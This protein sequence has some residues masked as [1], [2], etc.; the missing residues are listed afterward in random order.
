[1]EQMV[2]AY[3][4][5]RRGAEFA[6]EQPGRPQ[7]PRQRLRLLHLSRGAGGEEGLLLED[8]RGLTRGGAR[9]GRNRPLQGAAFGRSTSMTSR[10]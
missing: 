10:R 3:F 9:Y 6:V 7:D 8:R 4:A 1:M 2:V 5:N